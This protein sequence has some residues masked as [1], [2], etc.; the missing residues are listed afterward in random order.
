ML[1]FKSG[2]RVEQIALTKQPGLI[3]QFSLDKNRLHG[4]K[5]ANPV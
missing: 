2:V 4:N 1:E 5:F 3:G